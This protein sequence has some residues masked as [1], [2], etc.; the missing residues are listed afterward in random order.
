LQNG[1]QIILVAGSTRFVYTITGTAIV[2]PNDTSV[3]DPTADPTVTLYA[4]HPKGSDRQ[5]YV[6]FAR[7]QTAP[8]RPKPPSPPPPHDAAP[9]RSCGLVPCVHR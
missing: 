3:T 1:D 7:L 2:S 8:T 5:R 9:P 6:V 4:C